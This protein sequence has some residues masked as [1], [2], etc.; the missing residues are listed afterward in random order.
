MASNHGVVGSSPT[1][2]KAF[3]DRRFFKS[4]VLPFSYPFGSGTNLYRFRTIGL[5]IRSG[6]LNRSKCSTSQAHTCQALSTSSVQL[7]PD[8]K[9]LP[10]LFRWT[11]YE[12][13]SPPST[14][15]GRGFFS[16]FDFDFIVL[17]PEPFSLLLAVTAHIGLLIILAVLALRTSRLIIAHTGD[18]PASITVGEVPPPQHIR[19]EAI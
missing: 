17:S 8:F 7:F 2:R 6:S 18:V 16:F 10:S 15:R 1:G 12:Y 14:S 11:K 13:T 19:T 5:T 4:F 3:G 9:N